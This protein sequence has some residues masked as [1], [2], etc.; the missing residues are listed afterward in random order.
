NTLEEEEKI[1]HE[2]NLSTVSVYKDKDHFIGILYE[3]QLLNFF[4]TRAANPAKNQLKNFSTDLDPLI[5]IDEEE[6]IGKAFQMMSQ[7]PNHRIYATRSGQ[8]IGALSPKDILPYMAGDESVHRATERQD[9]V[10]A[11]IQIK[12]LISELS[13][14][15]DRL[16]SYEQAFAASPF[17]IHSVNFDGEILMAN[18]MLHSV[19]GYEDEELIGK[20][21]TD[22]YPIQFHEQAKAGLTRVK[23]TGFHPMI[24]TM[25]VKKNGD[26]IQVDIATAAR[27]DTTG[28]VV[29]TITIGKISDSA[30][31]L[32][33]L[34]DIGKAI[35]DSQGVS[36][37]GF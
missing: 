7:S 5:S 25:M 27:T 18:K 16:N 4:L 2:N 24:N 13:R 1:L 12:L 23:V 37:K 17:M 34:A 28:Q 10:N 20:N 11:N 15:Q 33:A 3:Y 21:I 32:E 31:M 29:G 30:K 36:H 26:Q 35:K 19:L 22:L 8:I 6:P 14:K 9:L